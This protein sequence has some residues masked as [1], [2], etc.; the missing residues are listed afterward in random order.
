[1]LHSHPDTPFRRTY[2]HVINA[3]GFSAQFEMSANPLLRNLHQQGWIRQDSL[4]L[5]IETSSDF[6]L[7]N[8]GGS[9]VSGL[10]YIGPMLRARYWECTAVPELRI[11]AAEIAECVHAGLAERV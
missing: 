7:I 11:R 2:D 4:G 9:V 3:T 5:G 10:Y 1:A 6:R 8:L